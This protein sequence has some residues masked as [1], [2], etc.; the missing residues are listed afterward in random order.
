MCE[1]RADVCP[2][3]NELI[4]LREYKK[5][6]ELCIRRLEKELS[7]KSESSELST[8]PESRHSKVSS[9]SR[10]QFEETDYRRSIDQLATVESD[11]QRISSEN[12]RLR[13]K[14][15][16][17]ER[18]LAEWKT[19]GRTLHSSVTEVTKF[20]GEFPDDDQQ[21]QRFILSDL[22]QKMVTKYKDGGGEESSQYVVL[23]GKYSR[24]KS[25]LIQVRRK[26]DRMLAIIAE[27]GIH[28]SD[29]S[30][31]GKTQSTMKHTRKMTSR[32]E[33]KGALH[34]FHEHVKSLTELTR[35]MKG[36]YVC[37]RGDRHE[38]SD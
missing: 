1:S 17:Y 23:K 25:K 28:M 3:I 37:R 20:V 13:A 7:A 9:K 36:Q 29:S 5:Q 31:A 22:V 24:T 16:R 34:N 18:E 21:T 27:H 4:S 14:A 12:L 38:E 26:C 2:V 30:S 10:C 8:H 15:K 32:S 33:A 35:E 11:L 6:A 19:F